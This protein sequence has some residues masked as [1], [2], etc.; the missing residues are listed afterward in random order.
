MP[1][2]MGGLGGMLQQL[3]GMN[4]DPAVWQGMLGAGGGLLGAAGPSRLPTT[5]GDAMVPAL[6]GG[7][8]GYAMHGML[9]KQQKRDELLDQ[10]LRQQAGLAGGGGGAPVNAGGFNGGGLSPLALGGL[11]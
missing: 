8:G 3:Q 5:M 6:Q 7:L 1:G 2:T 10:I 4:V 11:Y 9:E